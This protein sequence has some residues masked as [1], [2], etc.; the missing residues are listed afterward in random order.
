MDENTIEAKF[1]TAHFLDGRYT[2]TWNDNRYSNF[3]I[4]ATLGVNGEKLKGPFYYSGSFSSCCGG[5]NDGQI[6]IELGSD[7]ITLGAFVYDQF[8]ESFQGQNCPG[9]YTGSCTLNS[10]STLE[11]S[12]TGNDCEG[13]HTGGKIVLSKQF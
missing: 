6:S 3:P 4:S 7:G 13:D 12:F 2:G 5:S 11:I 1:G 9:T 10:F 8:L